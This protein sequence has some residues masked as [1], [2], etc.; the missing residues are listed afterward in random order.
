MAPVAATAVVF[1]AF[2]AQWCG[3]CKRLHKDFDNTSMITFYDVDENQ[4][5][6]D[7]YEVTGFPTIIAL[8]DGKEVTRTVGYNNRAELEGWMQR[9]KDR[10]P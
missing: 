4:E 6:A 9:V 10:N 5:A 8:V 7:N 1:I 3:P 2:T